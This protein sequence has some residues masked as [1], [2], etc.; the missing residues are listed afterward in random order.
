MPEARNRLFPARLPVLLVLALL[1]CLLSNSCASSRLARNAYA[2]RGLSQS[3]EVN[4]QF[5]VYQDL[6]R[7]GRKEEAAQ[8]LAG[9]AA[10][11][12]SP[13]LSVELANLYWGQN[14]REKATETLEQARAAFP[15]SRQVTFYLANA[16]QMRRLN[17][18]A[19]KVL[20]AFLASQPKDYA[21]VQELASLEIDASRPK[22]AG[23][24]LARIPE[25]ERD[26]TVQYLMGKAAAGSGRAK[27][28]IRHYRAAVAAD[29]GLM[30]AWAELAALLEAEG[31]FKGAQDAYQRMLSL[32]EE[33]PEVRAKLVRLAIRQKNPAKALAL[34][35]EGPTG[36]SQYLD[37]MS[38]LVE[39]GQPKQARQVY[40]MLRAADPASPDLPF[41][42]AVLTY[43]GEKNPKAAMAI[44]ARVPADNPNFDKS[45]SFRVQIAS[46]TGNMAAA[47]AVVREARE[48]FP[49]RREFVALEAAVKDK[50][51]DVAGAVKTLEEAV[52]TWPDDLDL[53]Y[54][55]GVG[56]EKLKRRDEAKAVMERI[57]AK[58]G[59][60][61]DALN[62]LG[63]SLAEEGRD[64]ERALAMI[65]KALEKEPDNPFFL[66]S[67]A[68]TL[69][70]LKRTDAAFAAIEK[71]IAHKVKDAIIW[72]HYG[73]IAV[74]AGRTDEARKAYRSALELGSETPAIVKK[75][76][77]AL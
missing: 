8:T 18:Q 77:E 63:Y 47:A 46:E 13:D 42:D 40:E 25:A 26:A 54:R 67:L 55:Y 4:Y 41:Y 6:L 59:S 39:A 33:S 10:G 75:K 51:G 76:L 22:E 57:V 7:Q 34:L 9:L 60:H 1:P 14:E 49:D 5:L 21:A 38:A 35:K 52:A 3:A 69:Y 50:A 66:D 20:E 71:A 74:A 27:D 32:G 36:K 72:E 64:L 17:D 53:L 73:D 62:Y 58:D 48:R 11:H 68:W 61:P 29:A 30:P 37:A 56:L 65:E 12:P 23:E 16:Y 28:A 19:I 24:L 43:E 31:D 45:L 44:L 15:A 2:A 70:K